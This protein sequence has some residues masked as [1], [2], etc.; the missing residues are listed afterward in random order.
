MVET[1]GNAGKFHLLHHEAAGLPGG[2]TAPASSVWRGATCPS[3]HR[4]RRRRT[5]AAAGV[6]LMG[7]IKGRGRGR[8]C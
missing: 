5:A 8:W 7:D 2:S 4:D 6:P 1:L 3:H